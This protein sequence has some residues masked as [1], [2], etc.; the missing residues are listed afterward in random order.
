MPTL[1]FLQSNAPVHTV[2]ATVAF[3]GLLDGQP[4][5]CEISLEALQDHFGATSIQ[6]ADLVVA[7]LANRHAIEAVGRVKLPSRLAAG[8]G[9]L[10]S[11]DF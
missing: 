9:L 10:L 5:T 11:S 1:I 7:F 3:P 6:G 2:N 8:R 4:V